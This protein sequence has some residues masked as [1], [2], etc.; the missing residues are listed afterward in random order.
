MERRLRS[1]GFYIITIRSPRA[2]SLTHTL[3]APLD[4]TV[5]ARTCP[6]P[7]AI[8]RFE[9]GEHVTHTRRRTQ[10]ETPYVTQH[11][12]LI[13]KNTKNSRQLTTTTIIYSLTWI[14]DRLDTGGRDSVRLARVWT[15]HGDLLTI[16]DESDAKQLT[17]VRSAR[18]DVAR[19]PG[20]G[21]EPSAWRR[22]TCPS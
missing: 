15:T 18:Q 16:L 19:W 4:P 1:K 12:E 13:Q 20:R 10:R 3:C 21:P 6:R 22:L 7:P 2:V 8:E 14:W 5:C 17:A 11:K 9:R